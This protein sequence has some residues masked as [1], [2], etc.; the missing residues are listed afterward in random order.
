MNIVGPPLGKVAIIPNTYDKWNCNQA[1]VFFRSIDESLGDYIYVYL[2]AGMFLDSIE[3]I[4][5]A[6]Q[7][8]I[9]VTKSRS[10]VLPLPPK[11]EQQKIKEMVKK[12]LHNCESLK[13]RLQSAQQTQL[14]LADALTDAA[15]N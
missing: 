5:T 4:G 11:N 1:I 9:S 10:I 2:L 6:G 8:N 13:S 12:M 15:L 7:D 14:H 3:L